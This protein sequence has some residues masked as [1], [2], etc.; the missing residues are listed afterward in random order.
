MDETALYTR[1][2][3]ILS[4]ISI[5]VRVV[6]YRERNVMQGGSLWMK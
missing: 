5:P 6:R 3:Q 4:K 2:F 1:H